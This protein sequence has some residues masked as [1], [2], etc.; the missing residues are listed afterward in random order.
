MTHDE[1][2]KQA[3]QLA[4]ATGV[5]RFVY[6]DAACKVYSVTAE[7]PTPGVHT[8][9]VYPNYTTK[10]AERVGR[11]VFLAVI[12]L[13]VGALILGACVP[14]RTE[15]ADKFGQSCV[16][17]GRGFVM[18]RQMCD[19]EFARGVYSAHAPDACKTAVRRELLNIDTP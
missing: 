11:I 13:F 19:A 1:A 10:N 2:T 5:T 6:T 9:F 18:C 16:A 12:A 17:S 3:Q 14:T 8:W 4:N 15:E 7:Y